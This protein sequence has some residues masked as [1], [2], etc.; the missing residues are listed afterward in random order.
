M[1][2]ELDRFIEQVRRWMLFA[3][4]GIAGEPPQS[5]GTTIPNLVFSNSFPTKENSTWQQ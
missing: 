5:D 1:G 2:I 4:Q 3:D